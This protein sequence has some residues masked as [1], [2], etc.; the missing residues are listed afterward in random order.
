MML[1]RLVLV[2]A[3]FERSTAIRFVSIIEVLGYIKELLTYL[4]ALSRLISGY[5][6]KSLSL[7]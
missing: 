2:C 1:E 4:V 6:A 7:S 5:V 3:E